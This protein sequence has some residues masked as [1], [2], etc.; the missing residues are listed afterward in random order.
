MRG[1]ERDTGGTPQ[2]KNKVKRQISRYMSSRE[3]QSLHHLLVG[4][5]VSIPERQW[6]I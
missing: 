3:A 2:I 1:S 6:L 5:E 4:V